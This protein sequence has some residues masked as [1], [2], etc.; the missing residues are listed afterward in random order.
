MKTARRWIALFVTLALV[1]SLSVTVF[2]DSY[3]YSAPTYTMEVDDNIITASAHRGAAP[4]LG[5]MGVNAVAGYS[6]INGGAP[7]TLEEAEECAALGIWGTTIN[8]NPDPYY[9][10]Y[11]YNFYAEE[12]GLALSE[13]ALI[14]N[15]TVSGP[16]MADTFLYAEYGNLSVSLYRRPDVLVGCSGSDGTYSGYDSQLATIASFYHYDDD[17]NL[18]IDSEYYQEG[19]ESYSPKLVSFDATLIKQVIDTVYELAAAIEEVEEE[20]GKTTRYGDVM[21]IAEDYEA[22]VYRTVAYVNEQLEEKGIEQKTVAVLS[23]INDDGTYTLYDTI[24]SLAADGQPATSMTSKAYEYTMCVSKSLVDEVGSTVVTLDQLLTADAIVIDT[25]RTSYDALLDTDFGSAD[26]EGIVV[27]NIPSTLYGIY[28]GSLE[29]AMGYGYIIGCLYGTEIENIEPVDLCAY[30]YQRFLHISDL[31]A[32]ETVIKTNF[33]DVI[34]PSGLSVTTSSTYSMDSVESMIAEGMAYLTTNPD[35]FDNAEFDLIGMTAYAQENASNPSDEFLFDDV[36]DDTQY[37]YE[38]VYWAYDLGITTGTTDTTFSPYQD[39]E[40]C[41]VVTF[42]WRAAG[43]P[44][45]SED[46]ENPFT[47]VTEE[48]YFYTAV[49]WAVENGITTGTSETT[50]SPYNLCER[51][52][53]VTFL[54][55]YFDEP[56]VTTS[57][58]PFTDVTT[59][60]YFYNAVLWASENGITTGTTDTTFSP[61]GTCERCMVVTFLH[62]AL[63]E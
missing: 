47:D 39:T 37:Y 44:E 45:V 42:L 22:Y 56:E 6:M 54:Y 52:Q 9:W 7:S 30:F 53:V 46:T 18:V 1:V 34:L 51:C 20:T 60:D 61:F 33:S 43:C 4:L 55:R 58:N 12:N 31:D 48:D 63:A 40:R 26:Y 11:F 35:K 10:N 38:P 36:Q 17:G 41:Q 13:D 3:T 8:D 5:M 62:R 16:S 15:S 59:E 2:A 50:F 25:D 24:D 14:N 57:T 49:L 29:S 23:A 19:D 21:E 27:A 28:H 32:L